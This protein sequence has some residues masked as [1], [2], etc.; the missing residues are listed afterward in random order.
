TE[1]VVDTKEVR[2]DQLGLTPLDFIYAVEGGQ[3]GQQAEIEQRIL[4]HAVRMNG[5]FA[6]GSLLRISPNRKA[7]WKTSELGYR[8]SRE[9]SGTVRKLCGAVRAIDDADLNPPER[10]TGF[11]VDV[12]ELETRAAAARESLK[13]TAKDFANQ[14]ATPGAAD[15]NALRE[16]ILRAA[17]FGVAGAA[18][19]SAL[20]DSPNDR[21]I[22]VVQSQSIGKELNKRLAQLHAG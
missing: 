15:L 4:Y 3:G 8:E 10:S 19:L 12:D 22:L 7:E 1:K 2:L 20:G 16:L 21:E 18:P 9:L 14:L 5:G 17:S 13:Q 11:N 6:P